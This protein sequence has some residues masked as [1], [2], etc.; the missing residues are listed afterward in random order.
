MP[1]PKLRLL[2]LNPGAAGRHGFHKVRTLLRFEVA[3]GKVQQLRVVEL[4]PRGD[5][6]S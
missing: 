2:H 5:L 1:D 4:G 3:A 6:T